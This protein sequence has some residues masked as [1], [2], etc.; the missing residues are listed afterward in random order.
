MIKFII[1]LLLIFSLASYSY[2]A[3]AVTSADLSGATI[4]ISGTGFGTKSTAAPIFFDDFESGSHGANLPTDSDW[5]GYDGHAGGDYSNTTS[6]SGSLSAHNEITTTGSTWFNTSYHTFT[7]QQELYY[8]YMSKVSSSP[9]G[10]FKNGRMTTE[11]ASP[12]AHYSI[13]GGVALSDGYAFYND[14]VTSYYQSI[15]NWPSG[16]AGNSMTEIESTSWKRHELYNLHSTPGVAD[17]EVYARVGGYDKY[18]TTAQTLASGQSNSIDSILLGLMTSDDGDPS[19]HIY[20]DDVYV[21]NTKSRVEICES[22]TWSLS[23]KCNPQ[24][25]VTWSATSITV[26]INDSNLAGDLY[27]FVQDSNGDMNTTGELLTSTGGPIVTATNIPDQAY[28]VTSVV[29][30]ATATD[31]GTISGCKWATTDIAYASMTNTMD[32]SGS[33]YTALSPANLS[34]STGNSYTIYYT[35]V[36]DEANESGD[37]DSFS[38]ASAPGGNGSTINISGGSSLNLGG[39]STI[40]IR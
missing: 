6:Y 11:D 35:C 33:L 25:A 24:P 36:D 10:V 4:T 30:S 3:P 9:Q 34:V 12:N 8:S 27:I 32:N 31:D 19:A 40:N 37:S 18:D 28:T 23:I 1:S 39:G 26:T 38:V 29:P 22:S 21:D 7:G 2:S 14:G 16:S 17:G 5:T 20:I 15:G 13:Q